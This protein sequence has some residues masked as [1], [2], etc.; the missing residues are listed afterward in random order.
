MGKLYRVMAFL[1][2]KMEQGRKWKV[3]VCITY[4]E[5]TYRSYFH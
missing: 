3:D 5:R 1:L 4:R 2:R